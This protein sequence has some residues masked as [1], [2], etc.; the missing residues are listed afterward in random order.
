MRS[1]V[2]GKWFIL[3]NKLKKCKSG[4]KVTR[5]Q[6]VWIQ[7]VELNVIDWVMGCKGG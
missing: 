4:D 1:Q 3:V 2:I 7:E 5:Y 6:Y